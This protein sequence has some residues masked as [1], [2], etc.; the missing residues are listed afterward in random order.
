MPKKIASLPLVL[1]VAFFAMT[2]H[3]GAQLA[4]QPVYAVVDH[5]LPPS[6]QHL[7][8]DAIGHAIMEAGAQRQWLFVPGGPGELIGTEDTRGYTAKVKVTYSQKTYSIGLIDTNLPRSGDLVHPTY[9]RW[10]HNLERDIEVRLAIDGQE[11]K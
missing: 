7:S 10:I 6:A 3:V 2:T 4:P 5:P 1:G 11:S 8:L 9:N